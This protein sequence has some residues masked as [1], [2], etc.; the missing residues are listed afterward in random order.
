MADQPKYS[1]LV[2]DANKISTNLLGF[3]VDFFDEA[4]F[5]KFANTE[6]GSLCQTFEEICI[7]GYF[8][9]G[10]AKKIIPN[11]KS[12][13]TKVRI[14]T[15]EHSK[16]P[17]DLKNLA[18]LRKI[19]D[20]GAEIRV[21]IRTHFRM[22]LCRSATQGLL[23]LGSFDFNKEGMNEER[24]DVGI[25]TCHPDLVESVYDYFN[26]VWNDVR[27]C[28]PLDEMYPDERKNSDSHI[29]TA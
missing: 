7:S 10:F 21:N 11:L 14:I 4:K 5:K 6:M 27:D 17:N 25:R 15:T 28:V 2:S 12:L 16:R 9:E 29:P 3:R 23:V 20:A 26:S 18:S 19:Q 1:K 8:S 24:R 13:N 22:F